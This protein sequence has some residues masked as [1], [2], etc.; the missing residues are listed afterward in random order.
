[1]IN[2]DSATSSWVYRIQFCPLIP[3]R[4]IV[5]CLWKCFL[6]SHGGERFCLKS[7]FYW[8][9]M[10]IPSCSSGSW[11]EHWVHQLWFNTIKLFRYCLPNILRC[12]RII[13]IVEKRWP[14]HERI[15][16]L[17]TLANRFCEYQLWWNCVF[18]LN[19]WVSVI[20]SLFKNYNINCTSFQTIEFHLELNMFKLIVRL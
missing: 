1:M 13:L 20:I 4:P 15:D 8:K 12:K 17:W 19:I 9:V 14:L 11:K 5:F 7:L 10:H 3:W 18:N 6:N 16:F 2:K